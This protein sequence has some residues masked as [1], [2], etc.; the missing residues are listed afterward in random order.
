MAKNKNNTK[1]CLC[2]EP[3]C[4][5]CLGINCE[6]KICPTHTTEN[7]RAWRKRWEF[8]NKKP[9]PHPENY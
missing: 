8:T 1:K 7:K 4:A 6:D 9:F 5:K 3:T 2:N